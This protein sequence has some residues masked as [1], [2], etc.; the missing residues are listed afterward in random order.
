MIELYDK[1]YLLDEHIEKGITKLSRETNC[2]AIMSA[3]LAAQLSGLVKKV[4]GRLSLTKA[5]IKLMET[6]NR[7]QIFRQLFL[8]FTNKFQWSYND[9]YQE[10]QTGQFA[11][12]FSLYMLYKLG[13]KT[14]SVKLYAEKYLNAFPMLLSGFHPDYN[15][16]ENQFIRCYGTRTFERFFLWFGFVTVEV[17]GTYFNKEN[18]SYKGTGIVKD[19]FS[20]DE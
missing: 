13:D 2:I 18:A 6:N 17:A 14:E 7:V 10:P 8:A 19:I 16:P 9:G 11:W 1:R 3:R 12:A 5:T 4:N 20:L 15:T